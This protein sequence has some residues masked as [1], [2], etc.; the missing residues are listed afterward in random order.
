[1]ARESPTPPCTCLDRM[2][3]LRFMVAE[4]SSAA[5]RSTSRRSTRSLCE[6][7]GTPGESGFA[8]ADVGEPALVGVDGPLSVFEL[9]EDDEAVG[10]ALFFQAIMKCPLHMEG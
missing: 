9:A 7:T 3:R 1:M 2:S 10:V 8:D 5:A 6:L 4:V